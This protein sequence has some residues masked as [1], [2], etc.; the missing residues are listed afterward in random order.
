[1]FSTSDLR[2]LSLVSRIL[3]DNGGLNLKITFTGWFFCRRTLISNVVM[4]TLLGYV[5]VHA[6]VCMG[7]EIMTAWEVSLSMTSL[8]FFQ[9]TATLSRNIFRNRGGQV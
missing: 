1:M 7:G 6:C 3:L 4:Y 9:A 8:L 5:C 2:G